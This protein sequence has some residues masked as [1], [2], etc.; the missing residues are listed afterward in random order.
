MGGFSAKCPDCTRWFLDGFALKQH[1]KAKHKEKR[2]ENK[3]R[4]Q[5]PCVGG[6]H[7]HLKAAI[8]AGLTNGAE[9]ALV[10]EPTNPYDSNAIK[11][12]WQQ[13]NEGDDTLPI[14][15]LGYVKKNFAADLS[16][17]MDK[18]MRVAGVVSMVRPNSCMVDVE[19]VQ[20]EKK[21]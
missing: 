3:M 18:G 11:V 16:H 10:R 9:V 15:M 13:S 7:H 12:L 14:L 1:F 20:N 2:M 8:E 6:Q 4:M 21:A 19:E 17:H 5:V